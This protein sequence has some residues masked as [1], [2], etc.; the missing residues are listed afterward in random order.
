VLKG[1]GLQSLHSGLLGGHTLTL[2]PGGIL[3]W[4]ERHGE[5]RSEREIAK[6][7]LV[8]GGQKSRTDL[9]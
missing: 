6:K 1:L 4:E 5:R 8:S 3:G 7:F 9:N 2:E